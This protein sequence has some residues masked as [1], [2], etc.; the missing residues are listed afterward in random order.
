MGKY[1]TG[2]SPLPTLL[3]CRSLTLSHPCDLL[4]DNNLNI[5][6][7]YVRGVRIVVSH[8]IWELFKPERQDFTWLRS[9]VFGEN[10]SLKTE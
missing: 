1:K 3:S 4:Y 7:P 9:P 5:S 2:V 6:Y 8:A 10:R